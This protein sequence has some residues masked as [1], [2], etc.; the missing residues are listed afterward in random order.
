MDPEAG[1][2]NNPQPML[3]IDATTRVRFVSDASDVSEF[4]R[5]TSADSVQS[6]GDYIEIIAD[7][8]DGAW[9]RWCTFVLAMIASTAA[10]QF[11]VTGFLVGCASGSFP[12]DHVSQATI[13]SATLCGMI[14]GYLAV[15]PL[16]D[17]FGRK[18]LLI[19]VTGCSGLLALLSAAAPSFTILVG[20]RFLSGV[21]QAPW[22]IG[23]NLLLEVVEKERRGGLGSCVSNIFWGLGSTAINIL[24]WIIIPHFGWRM[25]LV[26][27]AV[28][29]FVSVWL[30]STLVES[31]RWLL[32]QGRI[33]EARQAM[34][35]MASF[36][37]TSVPDNGPLR[38]HRTPSEHS[39]EWFTGEHPAWS[40]YPWTSSEQTPLTGEHS[41]TSS[42]PFYR[43]N[44]E[45]DHGVF[46]S[47]VACINSTF[48]SYRTLFAEDRLLLLLYLSLAWAFLRSG[49]NSVTEFDTLVGANPG[50]GACQFDY[51]FEVVLSTSEIV[52]GIA[53]M[54]LLERG[55]LSPWLG[56]R[57][58]TQI[59]CSFFAMVTLA[60]MSCNVFPFTLWA[61]ISR[62]LIKSVVG[63]MSIHAAE[64][65][66]VS[67][68]STATAFLYMVGTLASVGGSAWVY[69]PISHEAIG[70]GIALTF[71]LGMLV[72]F[73]LPET[74]QDELDVVKYEDEVETPVVTAAHILELAATPKLS[75]SANSNDSF[76]LRPHRASY[77]MQNSLGR[78]MSTSSFGSFTRQLSPD[79]SLGSFTPSRQLSP[80]MGRQPSLSAITE[81]PGLESK[82]ST[83]VEEE[84]S[85]ALYGGSMEEEHGG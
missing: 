64:L 78:C 45:P 30:V 44:P 69:L 80:G 29:Y 33:Q 43:G 12:D 79:G 51:D 34:K 73:M 2:G 53:I 1:R 68:R 22:I 67:L 19:Y 61:Y 23:V 40:N 52:V 18:T 50:K 14:M 48:A 83:I 85:E 27:T 75:R 3:P 72:T 17:V 76:R 11:L 24:A 60:L 16:A 46:D 7:S 74:A 32:S 36:S 6:I 65:F 4:Q 9:T 13:P 38:F 71:F 35:Y 70:L 49:Y 66:D 25:L 20:C 10:M 84:L 62:G 21:F 82:T 77:C 39:G 63:I 55:D 37:N 26:A 41:G 28:P 5:Q 47:V 31:P 58:G 42:R 54:P 57:V 81:D 56:G 8:G 59:F 15:A